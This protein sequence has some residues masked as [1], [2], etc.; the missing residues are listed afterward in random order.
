MIPYGKQEITQSDIDA[1]L[2][3]LKSPL[4]TQGPK[5]IEFENKVSQKVGASY[6]V[7]F[8]SATSALHCAALALGLSK[9]DWLWTSPNSFV[10]SS[11]CG[12]YC[13]A[14]VDFVDISPKTYNLDPNFLESK[15]KKTKKDK[16]PKVIVAVHFG[17]QSCD[18]ESIS[19]LANQY[20]FKIIEDASHALGGRYKEYPIGSCQ[21]SDITIFSFHPV[22]IITSAEGGMAL[23][24]NKAYH[25]TMQKLRNHG[26]TKESQE[27]QSPNTAEPWYYE[28]QSI[29]F[30]YRLSEVHAALGISQL[31]RLETYVRQRN[32]LARIYHENLQHL[33]LTLPY[34]EPYNYSAF[35]LYPIVLNEKS[36]IT[37]R[38]LF[39]H[40]LQ[41]NIAPQVHY[42][43]IHLQPFYAK[44]GFKKGDFK[45]AESYY[46]H[47]LSLPLF[48]TLSPH[49]QSQVI[50]VLKKH[51]QPR[52]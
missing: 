12:I 5:A 50:K 1:V 48:P 4:I 17:G 13:R 7:S 11:N 44:F 25:Q 31:Q 23:T 16:L 38:D 10:A 45:N 29:G 18:M 37:R 47:T 27:F 19:I 32:S 24:Q 36:N 8:N 46:D 34:I 42:I 14:K 52:P 9:G 15:L 6:A 30:N 39:Q 43:P 41:S 35:H 21:F 20:G 22:K 2:E 51:I 3:T 28:Q 40:F 49:E 33:Q 26:I